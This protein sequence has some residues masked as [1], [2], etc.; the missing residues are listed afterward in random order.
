MSTVLV[1]V[2]EEIQIVEVDDKN[3][4]VI[5]TEPEVSVVEVEFESTI[6]SPVRETEIVSVGVQGPAGPQGLQG[7]QG[8]QGP[9]GIQGPQG[10]IGTWEDQV[11]YAKQVDFFDES[12]IYTGVADVGSSTAAAV[13]RISK[14]VLAA[15]DDV[16]VTWA[17]GD[18]NFDNVWDNHLALTYV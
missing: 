15:D 2:E 3:S 10:P 16:T 12:T 1:S 18:A 13:W 7:I 8:P 6:V 9:Q 17:D 5:S 4:V 14:T 11:P